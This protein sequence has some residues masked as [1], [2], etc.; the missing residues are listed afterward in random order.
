MNHSKKEREERKQQQSGE[1]I[2]E[3]A[4]EAHR[5][6]E[7]RRQAIRLAGEKQIFDE[8]M[9]GVGE[10]QSRQQG[11]SGEQKRRKLE[12]RTL[13]LLKRNDELVRQILKKEHRLDHLMS[14]EEATEADELLWFLTEE[15]ELLS[16]L[17]SLRPPRTRTNAKTGKQISCRM[18]YKPEALNILGIMSRF[19]GAATGPELQTTVLCDERWMR[20]LGFNVTDVESGY[21]KRGASLIGKTREGAGGKF[22]EAGPL[23]PARARLEGPRGA[24]SWQTL[25]DHES[26]LQAEKLVATFN[27]VIRALAARGYF[28]EAAR[29]A[30]DSTAEEVVPSFD[31][32][33]HVRKK[34]KAQTK[35]RRPRQIEVTVLGFKAWFVMEVTTGI[36]V[37]MTVDTIETAETD[38]ARKLFDQA[39]KNLEGHSTLVSAALDRGFIDGDL[40]WWLKVERDINWVCPSKENMLVTG[41]ARSRV[42]E[43]IAALATSGETAL[44]TAQRAAHHSLANNKVQFFERE[45]EPGRETLVVAQVDELTCTEFYGPGGSTSGRVHSKKYRPTSLHAT[46]VLRWPDRNAKDLLDAQENDPGSKGPIVLL[47]PIPEP[48]LTRYDRYDERSLIENR[49][50][51]DGKQHFGLGRS[52]ARNAASIWS[53]TV[54]SALALTLYRALDLH[55]EMLEALPD[56]RAED[57]G[58]MR[59]RRQVKLLNRGK[60]IIAVDQFFGLMPLTEFARMAGYA[61]Q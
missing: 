13:R 53:A 26:R 10:Q 20:V 1:A 40:F 28:P 6:A 58:V 24:L 22:A 47:S 61:T 55:W 46:V 23:G 37:A 48:A 59:Y 60:L 45:G 4:R 31:G 7:V 41:E 36:P 25:A 57:L 35:A 33:G 29:V 5:L 51:R 16:A 27:A 42:H 54:F 19:V 21:T 17:E 8:E 9:Q 32:A 43:A 12:K 18:M 30:I 34:V 14:A 3:R 56:R 11:R 49:L 2:A 44:E 15:L 38:P 39:R 52:L 50:N